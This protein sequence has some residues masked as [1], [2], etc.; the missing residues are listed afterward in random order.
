M[1]W[2]SFIFFVLFAHL[3]SA[4][5]PKSNDLAV[6]A[7]VQ[8]GRIVLRWA[9]ANLEIWKAG[10]LYGY[11][12]ERVSFEQ[13]MEANHDSARFRNAQVIEAALKPWDKTDLRWKTIIA[14]NK[15]AGFLFASLYSPDKKS[16][17]QKKE[18]GFGILMKSCDVQRDMALAHGLLITDSVFKENEPQV[19]RISLNISQKA[20]RCA[21]ALVVVN[22]KEF[23]HY[24]KIETLKAKFGDRRAILNF[25]TL[26]VKDYSGY[27]IE[28]SE[29]SINYAA[30]NKTPF[31]RTNTKYDKDKPESLF[32]DSLPQN[33]KRYYYRV[34]G[35]NCFGENGPASNIVSGIGREALRQYPLIDSTIIVKN[36]EV[37]LKFHMPQKFDRSM[38]QG[39]MVFRSEKRAAGYTAVS[40]MLSPKTE[41]FKDTRPNESNYYKIAAYSIYGDSIFSMTT[42][43]KLID[44]TPPAIPAEP[45]GTIDSNG[46]VKI[47]WQPNTEKDLLGYRV[48]RSN[49]EN[50]QPVELT[51]KLLTQSSFRDSVALKTLTREVYY[52]IRA[53]DKVYNNSAYSKYCKLIRPDK[54]KPIAI[55]FSRILPT[56]SAVILTWHKSN[57]NDVKQYKLFRME[58]NGEWQ[59]VKTWDVKEKI[60]EYADT[61]LNVGHL[62]RYK[63]QVLDESGNSSLTESHEILFKPSFFPKVKGL[64][65]KA[66]LAE[67]RIELQWQPYAASYNYTLYKAKDDGSLQMFKTLNS[68]TSSFTDKELYPGHKYRYAIKATLQSGAETKLSE[69]LVVEF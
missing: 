28:R 22:P 52:S 48:Y 57:S 67:R 35:I 46:V 33:N 31:I 21:P 34:T 65:G 54:I 44:E 10:N 23:S 25:V 39:Y 63:M 30:V 8:K 61:A 1:R 55:V 11:K 2:L 18:M 53:V 9:P 16:T 45:A 7:H 56:D 13:Y 37:S 19:Y 38:L 60:R 43:A 29:D 69:V 24:Q 51:K 47:S 42:Y 5:L 6:L 59:M 50:E 36:N 4:Q 17:P 41:I 27:W 68:S 66:N 20:I 3:L 32:G 40:A 62:Y 58:Q 15:T 49:S 12:I 14:R 64:N 26:G